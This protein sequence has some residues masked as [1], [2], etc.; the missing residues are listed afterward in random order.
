VR[1]FDVDAID[2]G[3]GMLDGHLGKMYVL[4]RDRADVLAGRR[5]PEPL[6]LRVNQGDCVQVR[7]T[8]RTKSGPVTYTCDLLAY[9]P[10]DSSPGEVGRNGNDPAVAPG[11]TRTFTYYADAQVGQPAAMVRDWGDV[12]NNPAV[13]LYG[14]IVVGPPGSTYRDPATGASLDGRSSWRAD[15]VPSAGKPYRDFTLFFQDEDAGL[16]THRM[17]YESK[18]AG[19]TGLNYERSPRTPVL[20]AYAGD[21]VRVD[22]LA[23]WSEQAQVFGVE[24]HTWAQEP[25]LRGTNH[26]SSVTVG[27]LESPSLW[28]DAGAGGPEG[29]AGIYRY[30]DHRDPYRE[31]GMVGTFRVRAPGDSRAGALAPLPGAPLGV[32]RSSWPS[33]PLAVW[34]LALLIGAAAALT[35]RRRR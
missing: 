24:G 8:N 25:G 15:V 29:L 7:L 12:L 17:P 21:R 30:G 31:A 32:S 9:D 13:G 5:P 27:G 33:V 4:A 14:A 3:L 19:V 16:S 18:V 34:G 1:R 6:V 20:D 26:L 28:L 2:L 23:P 10:A 35:A 11:Q 22:V